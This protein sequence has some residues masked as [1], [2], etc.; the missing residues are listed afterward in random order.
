MEEE[1]LYNKLKLK[2][3][4]LVVVCGGVTEKGLVRLNEFCRKN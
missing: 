1:F 2:E 4:D 3:Y